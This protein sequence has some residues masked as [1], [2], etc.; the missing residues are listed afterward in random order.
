MS[1]REYKQITD[2]YETRQIQLNTQGVTQ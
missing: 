1:V 2:L